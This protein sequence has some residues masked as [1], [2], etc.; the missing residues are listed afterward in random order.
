MRVLMI[1]INNPRP[2][3]GVGM[4]ACIEPPSTTARFVEHAIKN[5]T[6]IIKRMDNERFINYYISPFLDI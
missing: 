2:L 6:K 5:K 1:D 4:Y 3:L